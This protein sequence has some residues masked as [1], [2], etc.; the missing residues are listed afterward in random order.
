MIIY[1]VFV[2]CLLTCVLIYLR[3]HFICKY[4][5][6]SN[7]LVAITSIILPYFKGNVLINDV[8]GHKRSSINNHLP[9]SLLQRGAMHRVDAAVEVEQDTSQS[10]P[11][12]T[13]HTTQTRPLPT[14][15]TTQTPPL[16]TSNTTQARPLRTSHT[17][18]TRPLRI[19]GWVN[20]LVA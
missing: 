5:L 17:T 15:N 16:R 4:V 1:Y 19:L 13:S 2:I 3:I 14:S 9:T 10:V 7:H 18:K 20:S 6:T 8:K 11:L 12:Q